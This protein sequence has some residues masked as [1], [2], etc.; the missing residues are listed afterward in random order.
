MLK[1]ATFNIENLDTSSS[2]SSP[3]LSERA[4]IL[5]DVFKRL[6]ADIVCLQEV[7]GQEL[8]NHTARDPRRNLSALAFIL[9]GS[10]YAQ[11]YQVHTVT[12]DSVPYDKRNLVI[13]S[14]WPISANH[15]Y[16][17]NF[18]DKLRYRKVTALPPEDD[19]DV[20]W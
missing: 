7:H 5:R 13:L 15:Q 11:Y 20:G 17:H 3:S 12:S 16:K 2:Q 10:D 4:P 9:E 14:R 18:I 19:K 1:I 6:D 8:P